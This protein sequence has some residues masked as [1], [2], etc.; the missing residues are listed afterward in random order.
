MAGM[1]FI[2]RFLI[3]ISRAYPR[4]SFSRFF[5]DTMQTNALFALAAATVDRRLVPT[6][7]CVKMKMGALKGLRPVV[8]QLP[9]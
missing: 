5:I 4:Y 7:S 9:D 3:L 1:A 2:T 8:I 6:V